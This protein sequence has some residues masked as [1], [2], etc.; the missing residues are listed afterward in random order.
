MSPNWIQ[1]SRKLLPSPPCPASSLL[2]LLEDTDQGAGS[3]VP[4]TGKAPDVAWA[5]QEGIVMGAKCKLS[6]RALLNSGTDSNIGPNDEDIVA[7][8]A[9]TATERA[10]EGKECVVLHMLFERRY[11][12]QLPANN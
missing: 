12:A 8:R 1:P 3:H 11:F 7:P 4:T 5:M 9:E 2:W 10:A 6:G